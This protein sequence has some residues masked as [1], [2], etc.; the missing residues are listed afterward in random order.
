MI[1]ANVKFGTLRGREKFDLEEAAEAYL[2]A[3]FTGG[4][5]CGVR[6][7]TWIKGKL[8]AHVLLAAPNAVHQKFH[9]ARGK[10]NLAAVVALFGREPEWQILDDDA[11]EPVPKWKGAPFLY[12]FTTWIDWH[13]PVCRQDKK[14][15]KSLSVPS[16]T[17]PVTDEIKENLDQWQRSYSGHDQIW[18]ESGAL[19]L[20]AYRQMADVNSAL[21]VEGRRLCAAVENGTGIP[22][23]YFLARYYARTKG[24][25]ERLC[26][27]CGSHWR[28][29]AEG[30]P[31]AKFCRFQF[32]CDPCRLISN[33]G[34]ST[35]GARLARIG[36]FKAG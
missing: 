2:S 30:P 36:E 19:E 20:P 13:P 18:M 28:T 25:D 26:P 1:L 35:D 4:Q 22:T 14:R 29:S 17:L 16:F 8:T 23:F 24:E 5:I 11:G 9:T 6:F 15:F 3:L 12:L 31:D 21:S 33:L 27:G 7:L 10:K 32:K 34:V